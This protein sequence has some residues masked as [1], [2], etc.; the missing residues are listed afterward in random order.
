MSIGVEQVGQR[1]VRNLEGKT[2]KRARHRLLLKPV[3][4]DGGEAIE[5][6]W[7]NGQHER[8][9]IVPRS[10]VGQHLPPAVTDGNGDQ[11]PGRHIGIHRIRQ[12]ESHRQ[13]RIHEEERENQPEN[14]LLPAKKL[15]QAEKPDECRPRWKAIEQRDRESRERLLERLFPRKHQVVTPESNPPPTLGRKLEPRRRPA[16]CGYCESEPRAHEK[17]AEPTRADYANLSNRRRL[18]HAHP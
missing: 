9:H 16:P 3:D 1:I 12:R 14:I 15:E 13:S 11:N 17:N 5:E 6:Q 8:E 2:K 18:H 7:R 4:R 10:A